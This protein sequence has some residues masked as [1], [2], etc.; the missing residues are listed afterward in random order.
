MSS[1]VNQILHF[2]IHVINVI[3]SAII[4]FCSGFYVLFMLYICCIHVHDGVLLFFFVRDLTSSYE[5]KK[6]T[7]G[8]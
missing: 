7:S 3:F 8:F 5:I 2:V 1:K 6:R 4:S